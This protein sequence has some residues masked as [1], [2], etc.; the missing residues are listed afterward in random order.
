MQ[1]IFKLCFGLFL[2]SMLIVACQKDDVQEV[3]GEEENLQSAEDQAT[4]D[5]AFSDAFD[6]VDEEAKTHGDLDGFTT[7][8][9]AEVRNECAEVTMEMSG[10]RPNIF[11][12]TLTINYGEGCTTDRGREITG[13]VITTFS[14]RIRKEGA[15]RTIEFEDFSINGFKI[16]GTKTIT[17]NGVNDEGKFSYTVTLRNGT[18]T[19]PA[20]KVIEHQ[21]TRT[22]TWVEGMDTNFAN[23][24]R[25]GI[26]DDVWEIT[27]AMEGVNRNGVAYK[28]RVTTPL[29][30]EVDCRWLT[31]G[32]LEVT[33]DKHPG[34]T[35]SIDYGDGSCDNDAVASA[36]D[37]TRDIK[38]PK[39]N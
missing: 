4:A 38:L 29:R 36:G 12:V 10:D 20:G 35:V 2:C 32:V 19:T 23:D 27:G 22:R 7:T 13:K 33:S 5:A 39:R 1:H 28:A 15:T 3:S 21:F 31:S 37:R 11:P 34:I 17:N 30:R 18:V 25:A 26:L 14:D 9:S 16:T 24:G 8:K 6:M